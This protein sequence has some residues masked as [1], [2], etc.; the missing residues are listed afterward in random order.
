MELSLRDT[1]LF[2][3]AIIMVF[4]MKSGGMIFPDK[5]D[6]FITAIEDAQ[7]KVSAL[8]MMSHNL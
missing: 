5:C 2:T 7:Y 6:L 1:V 8:K 4:Y 3:R